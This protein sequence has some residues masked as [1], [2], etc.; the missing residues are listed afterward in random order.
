MLHKLSILII[1]PLMGKIN[2]LRRHLTFSINR[3]SLKMGFNVEGKVAIVTGS[4]RGFGKEFAER[5]LQKGAKVCISDVIEDIGQETVDELKS[6][7]GT[8][9]VM[10]Q[11]LLYCILSIIT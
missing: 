3:V 6:K 10:F 1:P 9:N 8:E 4:A 11:R 2:Y 5:L 7:F